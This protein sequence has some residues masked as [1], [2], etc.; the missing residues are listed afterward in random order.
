MICWEIT[1]NSLTH[2]SQSSPTAPCKK[3]RTFI[4]L[5]S[6]DSSLLPTTPWRCW[7]VDQC[8][9]LQIHLCEASSSGSQ[10]RDGNSYETAV[11]H[12]T[13]CKFKLHCEKVLTFPAR[14][15]EE[16]KGRG[17]QNKAA[18]PPPPP[19]GWGRDGRQQSH[20]LSFQIKHCSFLPSFSW[21]STSFYSVTF[22]L[23]HNLLE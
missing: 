22:S 10:V 19:G 9:L 1:L 5:W 12:I 13:V 18:V 16:R 4:Y 21:V 7:Q 11:F 6:L 14:S 8:F 23:K 15:V 2:S 20:L 17:G 3:V